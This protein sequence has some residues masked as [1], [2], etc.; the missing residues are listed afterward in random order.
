MDE[1]IEPEQEKNLIDLANQLDSKNMLGYVKAFVEDLEG[2]FE[3]VN[4]EAFPWL[5]ELQKVPWTGVLCLGMGGSAAGGEFLSTLAAHHG[6]RPIMVQ[7]DYDLP[8][9][10]DASWLVLA[11]SHSGNT[12][13]TVQATEKA[14]N[15]GAT[16]IVIATGGIL[17]GLAET[18]EHCHLIPSIGGQPPRTAFG[19]I[20]S[21]QLASMEIL[22][23]LPNQQIEQR[24]TMLD[25]LAQIN[26]QFDVLSD[27]E[28]DI[29]LLAAT[30]M[31]HPLSVVGPTELTPALNRFKNQVNENAARFMRVGVLPEM[32]HN[33]SVA[34]GGVGEHAD[35]TN[36]DHV[37]LFL[38]WSQMHPRVQQ[39]LN[40]MVAHSPTELA[41]NLTGEGES[42][43]EVLLY[44][45]IIMDWLSV[46]LALLHGKDPEAIAP[47]IS[48]KDYL[49]SIQ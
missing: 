46:T 5:E 38:T 2:G 26:R 29:A 43:L 40:W 20:F 33:E 31:D 42:L 1:E 21:R 49:Q 36:E 17:A 9:W 48:L 7:R 39:R 3:A 24:R 28:G 16:V 15:L 44:H 10:F 11:T 32:N 14:L 35:S 8:A 22:G 37:L 19:H 6:N 27:P 13:E 12:E 23:I 47:I 45:C 4:F 18:S 34:W 30:M 41:W 25:R